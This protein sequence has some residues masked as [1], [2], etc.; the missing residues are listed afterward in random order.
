MNPQLTCSQRQ[1]LHSSVG[2][3]SHRYREVTGSNPVEV[4]IFFSSFFTK[5]HKFRSLRR[6]S[7]KQPPHAGTLNVAASLSFHGQQS[8]TADRAT[9]SLSHCALFTAFSPIFSL[10]QERLCRQFTTSSKYLRQIKPTDQLTERSLPFSQENCSKTYRK[11]ILNRSVKTPRPRVTWV[12]YEYN[13]IQYNN[14]I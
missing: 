10:F 13:T 14:F 6:S 4:L 1:W 12:W 9:S 11:T 7:I 3:T 2:R 8:I 5:L